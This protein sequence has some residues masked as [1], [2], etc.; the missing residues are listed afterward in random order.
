MRGARWVLVM[1]LGVSP[2]AVGAERLPELQADP[3][4]SSVSGLSSGAFMAVQYQVAFSAS[5]LGVGVVA[6]GPYACASVTPGGLV[7]C[8]SGAPRGEASFAAADAAASA[9]KI[10]PLAGLARSRVYLFSGSRDETVVPAVVAAVAVFYRRAGVAEANLRAVTDLPAGHAF[11]SPAAEHPCEVTEAPY[12]NTC[13]A[14]AGEGAYDQA[15]AILDHLYGPLQP[16]AADP[17][18]PLAFDQREFGGS[19]LADTGY[20]YLP[21]ACR[22]GRGRECAVHVVFHGCRQGVA[23]VGDA[24]TVRAGYN[25]WAET[26]RIIVLYPQV[27]PSLLPFNPRGCW[28]WWGYTG[29]DFAS[30]SAPQLAAIR[31][32]VER[33][34]H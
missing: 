13:P 16:P 26:N 24:I 21:E 17:P 10:D 12:L 6:G 33:L 9:G 1:L 20:L 11:L 14:P 29:A 5:T 30:R 22:A 25:R 3:G 7:G 15:G 19:D 4:R 31:A 8:M 34:T 32:M 28:D 27:A 23:A 2:V 18:P